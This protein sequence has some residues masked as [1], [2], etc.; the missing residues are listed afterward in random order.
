[1][2]STNR[3]FAPM[4]AYIHTPRNELIEAIDYLWYHEAPAIKLHCYTI[5]FL[6]QELIINFG[7]HFAVTGPQQQLRY[8][9]QGMASAILPGPITTHAQGK[10][11]ALGIM[12]KPFGLYRLCGLS[13]ATL[14]ERPLSLPDI[15][16]ASALTLLQELDTALTPA[17]KLL[18]MEKFLLKKAR[19]QSIPEEVMAL[20]TPFT[21]QKG[22]IKS[23]ISDKLISSKKYIHT[24]NTILGMAPKKYTHLG[25]VNTAVA[26]IAAYPNRPLTDIAYD[27]GFYDQAHFIRVFKT[28]AGITP[29]AFR[30]AV[31][32]QQVHDKMP[33]TIFLS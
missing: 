9:Q 11:K 26:Q 20:Q 15:W 21:L 33:N 12:L 23:N 10:Y 30:K 8:D 2:R 4:D 24:C 19:P 32:Q 16:G 17:D 28:F 7:D 25:L 5:P 18:I 6:H 13:A 31:K 14:Q 1:M 27:N 29:S 22:H 3:I